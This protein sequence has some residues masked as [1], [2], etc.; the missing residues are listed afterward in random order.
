MRNIN[1]VM[2]SI[3]K[4]LFLL[5]KSIIYFLILKFTYGSSSRICLINSIKGKLSIDLDSESYLEVGKFL[6]SAGPLYIKCCS[7]ARCY[8]GNNVFFNHNCSITCQDMISI[9]DNCNIANNVVIVDHDHKIGKFGV[10]EGFNTKPVAI[11]KNVWIGA[12]STILKGSIVGDGAVI[13]SGAVVKGV[14]PPYEVW[15]GVPAKKIRSLNGDQE[16]N[17][18]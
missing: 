14:V 11:G 18:V 3:F 16:D 2:K 6:M 7:N 8:I 15:G 12:N 9:G 10:I 13:A 17:K 5:L 1:C 4:R